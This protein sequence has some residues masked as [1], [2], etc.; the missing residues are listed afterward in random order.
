MWPLE[1]A[2]FF[3]HLFIFCNKLSELN[4]DWTDISLWNFIFHHTEIDSECLARFFTVLCETKPPTTIVGA[5][6]FWYTK[7]MKYVCKTRV[8]SQFDLSVLYALVTKIG[9]SA[10]DISSMNLIMN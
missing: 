5:Q 3:K 8:N 7:S 2:L 10:L 1:Y 6:F 9:I 4:I